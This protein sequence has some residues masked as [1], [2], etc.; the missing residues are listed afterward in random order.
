MQQVCAHH[1]SR[2]SEACALTFT[3]RNGISLRLALEQLNGRRMGSWLAG[4]RATGLADTC[5]GYLSCCA[6]CYVNCCTLAL[7]KSSTVAAL[8]YWLYGS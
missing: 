3:W 7:Y 5:C 4:E 2:G 8:L 1:L 6:I